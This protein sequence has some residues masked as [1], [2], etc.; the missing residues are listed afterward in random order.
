M[1]NRR[2]REAKAE[3]EFALRAGTR[4]AGNPQRI[5][6]ALHEIYTENGQVNAELYVEQARQ[7]DSPLNPTLEWDDDKASHEY[8][9]SQARTVIRAVVVIREN[10]A[11]APVYVHVDT[12]R[13][14]QPATV[15]VADIGMYAVALRA[16]QQNLSGAHRSIEELKA[17]AE[18]LPQ[19]DGERMARITLA[20]QALHTADRA[21]EAIH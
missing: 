17:V 5:G 13:G 7:P 10:T 18:T 16:L 2:V 4:V 9:L 12:E 6:E 3:V 11:R 1:S 8:R 14:Y 15:V 20:V 19:K 21:V